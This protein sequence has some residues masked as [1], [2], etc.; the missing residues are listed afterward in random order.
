[1]VGQNCKFARLLV[2]GER[3]KKKMKSIS[4][5]RFESQ[6]LA[7]NSNLSKSPD[8]VHKYE[9]LNC[10]EVSLL[11]SVNQLSLSSS[12]V[13]RES[14]RPGISAGHCMPH[15]G[16]VHCQPCKFRSLWELVMLVIHSKQRITVH[17]CLWPCMFYFSCMIL[18]TY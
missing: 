17:L 6:T 18:K 15:Y 12:G 1:M 2:M 10:G 7:S 4:G 5:N 13:Q 9:L 3:E 8:C 14:L 11:A 16:K